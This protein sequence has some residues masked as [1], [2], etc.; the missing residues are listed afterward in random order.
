MSRCPRSPLSRLGMAAGLAAAEGKTLHLVLSGTV[1]SLILATRLPGGSREVL[2]E[3]D[4]RFA[5]RL[6]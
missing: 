4:F 2:T 3:N 1:V 5:A 6:G